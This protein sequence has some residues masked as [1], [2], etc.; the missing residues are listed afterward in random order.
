MVVAVVKRRTMPLLL[1]LLPCTE[2]ECSAPT[3]AAA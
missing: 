3:A 1:L 2:G